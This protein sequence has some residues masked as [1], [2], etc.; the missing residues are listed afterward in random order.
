TVPANVNGA[1]VTATVTWASDWYPPPPNQHTSSFANLVEVPYLGGFGC[2]FIR[3]YS[4]NNFVEFESG[5]DPNNPNAE[6]VGS[7][8]VGPGKGVAIAGSDC[9][10]GDNFTFHRR[11]RW[12]VTLH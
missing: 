5:L 7:I 4:Q 8:T 1:T 12:T 11:V 2:D 6:K 10:F 3:N 9:F